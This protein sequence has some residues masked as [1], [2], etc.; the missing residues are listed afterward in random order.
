MNRQTGRFSSALSVLFDSPPNEGEYYPFVSG[1]EGCTSVI[2]VGEKGCWISHFWQAPSFEADDATFQDQVILSL[3]QGDNGNVNMKTPFAGNTGTRIPELADGDNG[4]KP[5]IWVSTPVGEGGAGYLFDARV[6]QIE[7]A[8]VG[9]G[10]AFAGIT[11]QRRGYTPLHPPDARSARGKVLI[12]YT[13]DQQNEMGDRI[14]CPQSA[15][16][17]LWLEGDKVADHSWP[18]T[19]NQVAAPGTNNRKRQANACGPSGASSAGSASA[20]GPSASLPSGTDVGSTNAGS[21]TPESSLPA[22]S[23][24]ASPSSSSGG[25]TSPASTDTGPITSGPSASATATPTGPICMHNPVDQD[26]P[27]CIEPSSSSQPFKCSAGSNIGLATYDPATWCGCNTNSGTLYPTLPSGSGDAACA[28]TA[29]PSITVNPTAVLVD[30]ASANSV[31]T[32]SLTTASIASAD[33]AWSSA[34]A[35]P[36]AACYITGDDGFGDSSFEVYGI[37][38]WAGED[39][40][41]LYDQL[42]GCGILDPYEYYPDSQSEFQGRTRKTG[43]A[44]FGL[45]FFKGGCVERAVH[46]AGGPSPNEDPY[47]IQCQHHDATPPKLRRRGRVFDRNAFN[48]T[49]IEEDDY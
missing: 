18:A 28:Y 32:A 16:Y 23:N 34:A 12:Q 27:K 1:L 25:P 47:T 14:V 38:G 20:T 35:V 5:E 24:S 10:R 3:E 31:F 15:L 29:P 9:P 30:T 8:L 41:K 11:P 33:A 45:G 44:Y 39:G 19:G 40:S 37:N 42:N 43:I 46:S 36:S 13:N 17:R 48:D 4:F 26:P 6:G 7:Q 2:I 49:Y 21:T 22:N